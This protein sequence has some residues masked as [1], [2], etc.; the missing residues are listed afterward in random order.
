LDTVT[1]PCEVEQLQRDVFR[2]VLT[3]GLN[4]QIRRMC[5]H[6]EYRVVRLKRIRIMH[7]TLDVV[8]GR[9]RDLTAP[10]LAQIHESVRVVDGADREGS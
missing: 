1:S 10:E 5:E 2:I 4:R 8:E 7:I 3:Q 9:W 6:F